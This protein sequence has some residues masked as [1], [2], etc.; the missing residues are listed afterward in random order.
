MQRNSVKVSMSL[1]AALT[2]LLLVSAT[3]IQAGEQVVLDDDGKVV[4]TP[5]PLPKAEMLR[6]SNVRIEKQALLNAPKTEDASPTATEKVFQEDP[7]SPGGKKPCPCESKATKGAESK[8]ETATA[9]KA[10]E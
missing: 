1:V 6:L 4:Q 9:K 3:N 10:A 2:A 8:K 7:Q 5:Q